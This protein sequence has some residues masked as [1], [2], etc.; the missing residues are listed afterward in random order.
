MPSISLAETDAQ[1]AAAEFVARVRLQEKESYR[2]AALRDD[3]GTV[4][5]VA[6][7]RIR[8]S[9][10]A[11]RSCYV[12][13]LITD[14]AT[15]SHGYGGALLTWVKNW[16][17]ANGCEHFALDSCTHRKDAHRFYLRERF[18]ITCFHFSQLLPNK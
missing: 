2:L 1:I 6:G 7:F 18:D 3:S 11:G 14:E 15:R 8:H 10:S 16:A 13:D 9:L 5:A 17:V 4:R 12:D